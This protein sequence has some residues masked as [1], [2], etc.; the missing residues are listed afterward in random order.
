VRLTSIAFGHLRRGKARAALVVAGLTLGVATAVALANVTTALERHLGEELDRYGANIVVAPRTDDLDVSYGGVSVSGVSYEFE[1]LKTEDLEAIRSIDYAERLAVVAP[2]LIGA[3]DAGGRRTPVAGV[4]FK[5]TTRLKRWWRVA[6]RV[7][8]SPDEVLVGYEAALALGVVEG[9]PPDVALGTGLPSRPVTDVAAEEM[10]HSGHITPEAASRVPHA[11]VI[12]RETLRL[13]GREFR[14]AG[15]LDATGSAD[16]RLV[17]MDLARAQEVLNRPGE[18]S[19]VEVSALCIACPVEMMV[20]QIQ[21]AL[22]DARVTAVQQAVKTR[23]MTIARLARFGAALA[24]VVLVVAALLVFV[25]MTSSVAERRR[26]IGVLRA[27]GFRRSHILKILG[28]ETAVLGA[29]GGLVGW[30]LGL[31]A[32]SVASHYFTEGAVTAIDVDPLLALLAVAGAIAIGCLGALYPA[33]KASKLDPT[34]ALRY[35]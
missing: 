16:D 28:L 34:E 31:A 14:V 33:L 30:G 2:V 26:E 18:V 6:G 27:V 3:A 19:L 4:D 1:R 32:G 9:P 11:E 8:A 22:P 5:E 29:I 15:V 20:H 17:F 21:L 7:P 10:D 24:G 23:S 12:K 13:G 25:T 35:V